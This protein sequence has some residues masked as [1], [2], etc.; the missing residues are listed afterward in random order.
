MPDTEIES[1]IRRN[2]EIQEQAINERQARPTQLEKLRN[3][4]E[5]RAGLWIPLPEIIAQT[6]IMQYNARIHELKYPTEAHRKPMNIINK[7]E[8]VEGVVHSFYKYVE[9]ERNGQRRL[10]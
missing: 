8:R 6:H 5:R 2:N 9:D 7:T 10:F 3:L 4:F 1:T